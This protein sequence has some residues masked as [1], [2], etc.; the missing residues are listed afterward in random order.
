[1]HN[2]KRRLT[3]FKPRIAVC[4]LMLAFAFQVKANEHPFLQPLY[5]DEHSG[6]VMA[7]QDQSFVHYAK[8]ALLN[9]DNAGDIANIGV[10]IGQQSIAIFDSGGAPMVAEKL[11]TEIRKLSSLPISHIIIS[12]A[13][14][15]HWLGLPALLANTEAKLLVN[16]TFISALARRQVED[17][18][19]LTDA[20][21]GGAAGSS[22]LKDFSLASYT[23]RVQVV[24]APLKINLGA[25]NLSLSNLAVSHTNN[26][27]LLWDEN[28][29]TLWVGDLF[30]VEHVPTFEASLKGLQT[31]RQEI[32]A[33]GAKLVMPGHGQAAPDWH[34]KWQ[35]QWRYFDA[36]T[37]NTRQQ[38]ADGHS[39]QSSLKRAEESASLSTDADNEEAFRGWQLM[40]TFHPRNVT[41]AYQQLEWE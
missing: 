38:I 9:A 16:Q 4:L 3:H 13:H 17:V 28:N 30:F 11:L 35:K 41:R 20:L 18:A 39:L 21:N 25:R 27:L 1:M 31:S 5:Q 24:D 2:F 32:E 22:E 10:L 36:L 26:D 37:S 33:Y 14:P 34:E 23:D 12:H 40:P 6:G 15:D 29:K 7:H 19:S 8:V